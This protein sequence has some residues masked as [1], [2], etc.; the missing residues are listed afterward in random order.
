M[1]TQVEKMEKS[2]VKLTVEVEGAKVVAAIDKAYEAMKKDFHIQGFRKGKVPKAVIEKMY[3]VEVF[4][5][6]A[7]DILIDETLFDAVEENKIEMAARIRNNELVVEEMSKEGMK[8]TAIITVKPE[9]TLGDYKGLTVEVEKA[10]VTDEEVDAKVAAEAQKN[11]REITVTDR[12]VMPQDKTTI[13]FEGFVDGE[14]FEGGKGTDYPLVIGSKSFIDNFEDQLIGKNIGEEVEVNVTFPTEYHVAA[15]AGKPAM[16][17]VRVKSITVNELPE[18]N[19]E[20][21]ADIS[22]FETLAEYKADV[23][24]KLEKEKQTANKAAAEQQAID[25][26]VE[27]A[28][29]E[30]P[31]AMIEENVDRNV[32]TFASRMQAQGLQLEQY[33]QFTGQTMDA[34]RENFKTDSEK[35]IAT[36]LVLEK[37]AELENITVSDEEADE[38]LKQMALHYNMKFEDIKKSFDGFQLES[39][40]QDIKVQNAAKVITE[41]ANVVEK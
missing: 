2:Q 11:A 27:N 17:K 30:V 15:L 32:Q 14:T 20:F 31:E 13:D 29:I 16:F 12:A 33:L 7:A 40:K 35:Q 4:Y 26:A 19:D 36:R 5:N 41:S 25:K 22:E 38:E 28:N 34:F 18:I 39:L 10:E 9:V 24:A 3:G 8:Y 6:K 1:S 23:K 21:A 37:V